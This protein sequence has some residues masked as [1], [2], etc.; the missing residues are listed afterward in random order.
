M[1]ATIIGSNHDRRIE[2]LRRDKRYLI[3]F[4]EP[5]NSP[6]NIFNYSEG[7]YGRMVLVQKALM[8]YLFC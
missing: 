7:R 4:L 2:Y 8:K 3:H 6:H 5:T 1:G